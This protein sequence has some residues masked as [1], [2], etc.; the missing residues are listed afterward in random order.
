MATETQTGFS[1]HLRG[2]TVTTLACL[3]GVVAALVSGVLVGTSPTAATDSR[4]VA[5]L[6]A[7]VFVQYPLFKAIG[8][9]VDEFGAKDHLYVAFMTFTLWFIAFTV[10]LT[11]G[12]SL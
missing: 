6:A 12:V 9:D 2:V 4:S 8:I 5:V 1:G 7:F 11:S 3:A 10:L